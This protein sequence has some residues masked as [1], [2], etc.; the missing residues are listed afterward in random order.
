VT[1]E[2][3]ALIH[4]GMK[5]NQV[6]REIGNPLSKL[7]IPEENE[8]VETYRYGVSAGRVGTVRFSNGI[9]TD[10]QVSQP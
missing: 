3:F 1:P 7:A 10:V 2:G 4:A 9:V 5:R 8:L 6:L